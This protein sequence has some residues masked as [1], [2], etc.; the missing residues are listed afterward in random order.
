MTKVLFLN[1]YYCAVFPATFF[2]S[3]VAFAL[4]YFVDKY[5]LMVSL[6]CFCI[7]L[8][9]MLSKYEFNLSLSELGHQL[10]SLV[11]KLPISAD[12]TFFLHLLWLLLSWQVIITRGSRLIISAVSF[13]GIFYKVLFV[14]AQ[15]KTFLYKS[16]PK[17]L[18]RLLIP[19]PLMLLSSA[20]INHQKQVIL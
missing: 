17:T 3:A 6:G 19:P 14:Y 11:N 1:F 5:S 16:L 2:F 20:Q 13:L 9:L 4:N 15:I 7:Q 10:R 18:E 8:I 12:N